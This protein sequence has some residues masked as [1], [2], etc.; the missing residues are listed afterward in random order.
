[1]SISTLF[2]HNQMTD[3]LLFLTGLWLLFSQSRQSHGGIQGWSFNIKGLFLALI[4]TYNS[5]SCFFSWML[6]TS[7]MNQVSIS[8]SNASLRCDLIGYS[9]SCGT[10]PVPGHAIMRKWLLLSDVDDSSSGARGY[11]KASII[12]LGTGDEPPVSMQSTS[13]SS[14][15]LLQYYRTPWQYSLPYNPARRRGEMWLRSKTT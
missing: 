4:M 12:V 2:L 15:L 8:S 3:S 9:L 1:M 5:L 13:A 7:L 6:A 14:S 10:F 11:L